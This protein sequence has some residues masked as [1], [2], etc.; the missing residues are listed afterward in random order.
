MMRIIALLPK[1]FRV[2]IKLSIKIGDLTITLE[3][4]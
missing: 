3:V 1:G 2:R 4:L